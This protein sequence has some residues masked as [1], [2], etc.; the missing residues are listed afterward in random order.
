[1][2]TCNV[3]DRIKKL[4]KSVDKFVASKS[5]IMSDAYEDL[6]KEYNDVSTDLIL[7]DDVPEN[8]SKYLTEGN[9]Q[10]I[11]L[12]EEYSGLDSMKKLG[13]YS[14]KAAKKEIQ[15][16]LK[17]NDF[18]KATDLFIQSMKSDCKNV[19]LLYKFESWY[20]KA[21]LY[22][23]LLEL[24][25]AIFSYT[26]DPKSCEKMGDVYVLTKDYEKAIEYYLNAAELTDNNPNIY[27]KLAKLF[28]QLGDDESYNMCIL[29]AQRMSG[30]DEL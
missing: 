6:I 30:S 1:M 12:P 19:S 22:S 10:T 15:S 20:K 7:Q 9:Y 17:K 3:I 23:E 18:S 27:M 29:Q 13:E 26:F 5:D 14:Y 24:Y 28:K 25:K 11:I 16:S 2:S 4:K 8:V 21:K